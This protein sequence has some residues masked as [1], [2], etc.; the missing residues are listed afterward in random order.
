[1]I[2]KLIAFGIG[3][4]V[5]TVFLV[6]GLW[7]M[8]K[9]QKL[10]YSFLGLLGSAALGASLD[11]IPY[12]G[13]ALAVIALYLSLRLVTRADLFPDVAFT[14]GVAYALVFC[15]NLFVLGA[16]MGDLRAVAR[17]RFNPQA[18]TGAMADNDD[19]DA[20]DDDAAPAVT[21]AKQTTAGARNAKVAGKPAAASTK[22]SKT[23]T[24]SST[25]AAE[26]AK[27][28]FAVRCLGTVVGWFHHSPAPDT[29]VA[30]DKSAPGA[31]ANQ[32]ANGSS[33]SGPS[34]P[35]K[36]VDPAAA[37]RASEVASNFAL[38]GVSK[39]Q[40]DSMAIVF[41]GVKNYTIGL[42]ES[43]PM[44]TAKGNKITVRCDS[45]EE[46][47]IVLNVDGID[48]ALLHR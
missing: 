10:D 13:H 11:M 30:T 47:K 38:K 46:R 7:I 14:V 23:A 26:P 36:A 28:N 2:E 6:L 21:P 18:A 37:K 27:P 34:V 41:S 12:A 3:F 22:A 5:E 29:T 4:G 8:I 39:G 19:A 17:A 35:V 44:E 16:M 20:D 40:S 42:G 45:V 48:V 1:M 43:L 9:I 33:S 32:A 15:M 31:P 24:K 25:A